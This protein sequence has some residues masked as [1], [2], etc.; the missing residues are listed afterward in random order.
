MKILQ[1]VATRVPPPVH[2]PVSRGRHS[3]V[4]KGAGG[5]SGSSAFALVVTGQRSIQHSSHLQRVLFSFVLG[6]QKAE[7]ERE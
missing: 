7:K 5:A 3:R 6:A 1:R 4:L 2:I